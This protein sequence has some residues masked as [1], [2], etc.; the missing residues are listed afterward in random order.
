MDSDFSVYPL[1]RI[2][3]GRVYELIIKDEYRTYAE[4]INV[5]VH[6]PV[7]YRVGDFE[8]RQA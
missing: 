3:V 4:I 8:G 6:N 5:E 2:V 1:S 7:S